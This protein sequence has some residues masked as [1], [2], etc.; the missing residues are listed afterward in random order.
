MGVRTEGEGLRPVSHPVL[1]ER[2]TPGDSGTA[3]P[4]RGDCLAVPVPWSRGR[5][6]QA[7]C[8]GDGGLAAICSATAKGLTARQKPVTASERTNQVKIECKRHL[9]QSQLAG[10]ALNRLGN[11]VVS[12]SPVRGSRDLVAA[13][14]T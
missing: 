14:D 1:I 3:G 2:E 8:P 13:R 6:V 10:S 4:P 7:R 5:P 11:P 12:Y 9:V